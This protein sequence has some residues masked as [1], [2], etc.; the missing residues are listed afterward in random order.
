M[1]RTFVCALFGLFLFA[2]I[3]LADE[4]KGKITK[5]D[6]EKKTVTVS[7]D[8]KDKDLKI[9]DDAKV[10]NADGKDVK[11]GIKSKDLHE[12]C[13]VVVQCKDDMVSEIKLGKVAKKK[14]K[15]DK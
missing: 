14:D 12:G 13:E 8:G 15:K 1:L 2:G 7:V 5:I 3:I 4:L 9:A 10:L 6:A 11:D